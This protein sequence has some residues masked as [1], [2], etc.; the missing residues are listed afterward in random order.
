MS[1]AIFS[2]CAAGQLKLYCYSQVYLVNFVLLHFHPCSQNPFVC[3]NWSRNLWRI[4]GSLES[5][6]L[7]GVLG[8]GALKGFWTNSTLHGTFAGSLEGGMSWRWIGIR[9]DLMSITFCS[10]GVL[11]Y[12]KL[13]YFLDE[14][15]WPAFFTWHAV[16]V[17]LC[18]EFVSFVQILLNLNQC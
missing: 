7:Q 14:N 4:S 1:L 6:I 12:E 5:C 18:N 11:F 10:F 2:L 8:Q 16:Q 9:K 15:S 3:S 13:V 17:P